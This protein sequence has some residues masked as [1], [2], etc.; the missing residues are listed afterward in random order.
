M[1]LIVS[2]PEELVTA[3]KEGPLIPGSSIIFLSWQG[4]PQELKIEKETKKEKRKSSKLSS[5]SGT[6]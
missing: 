3:L 5:K 6:A 2:M 1:K 4:E